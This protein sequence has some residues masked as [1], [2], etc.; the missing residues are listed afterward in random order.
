ML[1]LAKTLRTGNPSPVQEF[2]DKGGV[3]GEYHEVRN[4]TFSPKQIR[5]EEI[6][7]QPHDTLTRL[8]LTEED[9]ADLRNVQPF[10]LTTDSV[11]LYEGQYKGEDTMD[12]ERCFV[13]FIRPRQILSG[14]ALL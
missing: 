5:Y 13:E 8:R 3:T 2:N 12:G 7:E 10:L 1:Q 4:V 14:A 11:R 9:F 6:V